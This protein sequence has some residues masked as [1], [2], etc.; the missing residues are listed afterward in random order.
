MGLTFY[1][2]SSFSALQFLSLRF[3]VGRRDS[4]N[5]ASKEEALK[6]FSVITRLRSQ[7]HTPL[8]SRSNSE[9]AKSSARTDVSAEILQSPV[10]AGRTFTI[11]SVIHSGFGSAPKEDLGIAAE[12]IMCLRNNV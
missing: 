12:C 10:R 11:D 8:V 5:F 7:V 9:I 1:K 6:I 4:L 3:C 2:V